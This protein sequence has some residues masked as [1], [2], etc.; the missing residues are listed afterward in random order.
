MTVYGKDHFERG[1]IVEIWPEGAMLMQ[2]LGLPPWQPGTT[3]LILQAT[4]NSQADR[5]SRYR[6]VHDVL[7][8]GKIFESVPGKIFRRIE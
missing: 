2:W 6:W 4:L 5:G 7:I 3:A 1:E 8:D